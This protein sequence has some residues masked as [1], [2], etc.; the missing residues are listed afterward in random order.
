MAC[1]PDSQAPVDR[2]FGVYVHE[3]VPSG[4]LALYKKST[5]EKR[6]G[7]PAFEHLSLRGVNGVFVPFGDL[8]KSMKQRRQRDIEAHLRN[9]V[10]IS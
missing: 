3:G 6:V 4:L 8:R 1:G 10:D 5:E 7:E 9:E 2:Q